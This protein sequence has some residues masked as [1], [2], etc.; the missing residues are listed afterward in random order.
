MT[1]FW[2]EQHTQIYFTTTALPNIGNVKFCRAGFSKQIKPPL[3]LLG[4]LMGGCMKSLVPFLLSM[5]IVWLQFVWILKKKP[6]FSWN[7][8]DRNLGV[9]RWDNFPSSFHVREGDAQS[10]CLGR[11][12]ASGYRNHLCTICKVYSED[13]NFSLGFWESWPNS[14][15]YLV[16]YI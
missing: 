5:Y 16:N 8:D 1:K 10:Y 3:C 6:S 2:H 13:E 14:C 7:I 9:S 12:R 15:K 11:T 4:I